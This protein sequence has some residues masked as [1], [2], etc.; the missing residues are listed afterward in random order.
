MNPAP[1]TAKTRASPGRPKIQARSAAAAKEPPTL[2]EGKS[3]MRWLI[4]NSIRTDHDPI[5]DPLCE[6]PREST[7]IHVPGA[8]SSALCT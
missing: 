7:P 6:R 2:H 3:S 8:R 5:A 4:C 1:M